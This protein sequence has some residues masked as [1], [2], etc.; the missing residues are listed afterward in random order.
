MA[1]P[2]VRSAQH[3]LAAIGRGKE[4]Q[5]EHSLPSSYAFVQR[6]KWPQKEK[7]GGTARRTRLL[8]GLLLDKTQAMVGLLYETPIAINDTHRTGRKP[9]KRDAHGLSH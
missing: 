3:T 8:V 7:F 9:A 4:R 2:I 6:K 1:V 5:R